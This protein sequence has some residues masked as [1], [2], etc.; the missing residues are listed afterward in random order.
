M[1]DIDDTRAP[2][3]EHLLELRRRLM[4]CIGALIV[5]FGVCFYFSEQI[6]GFLVRPLSEAFGQGHGR[7]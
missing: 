2:L 5:S 6:F 3:L 1:K 7:L 4:W